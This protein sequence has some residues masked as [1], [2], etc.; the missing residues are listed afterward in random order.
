LASRRFGNATQRTEQVEVIVSAPVFLV[1]DGEPIGRRVREILCAEGQD[2]PASR[3]LALD[4][5]AARLALEA[6]GLVIVVLPSDSERA[7][8]AMSFIEAFGKA[9]GR[10]EATVVAVGPASD[11]KL[12]LRAL[13]GGIDDYVDEAELEAELKAALGRWRAERVSKGRS[14][15]LIALLAPSGGSGSSTLAVNVAA[16]LAKEHDRCA[17]IDLKLHAGDL[18]PLLDLRPTYSLADLCLSVARMDRSL[19]ERTLVPHSSGIHLLAPP[20]TLADLTHITPEGVEQALIQALSAFP[21]VVVDLDHSF[22]EEQTIALRQADVVLLVLRLDFTS[23]RNCRR[24]LEHLEQ[25]GVEREKVRL[26]VNRY[27]QPK[28][29]AASKA[30]EALGLKVTHYIPDDPKTVNRA[31]NNGVPLIVEAPAA[32]ISRNIVKLAASVNGQHKAH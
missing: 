28:E 27:G 5:A 23:L 20:R 2:L 9:E 17:L 7:L 22:H 10:S 8:A 30:E 12:V 25:I 1:S 15:R 14:G 16:A 24:T 31:N 21:Y 13:R 6:P 11:P 18:A 32:R 3:T 4:A 29:I 26:V 19:F